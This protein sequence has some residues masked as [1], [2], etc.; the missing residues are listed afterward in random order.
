M[1]TVVIVAQNEE[2]RI[3]ACVESVKFGDQLI[4]VDSGSTDGTIKIASKYVNEVIELPSD[5]G[6]S[7]WR[8][9]AMKKA[10]GDWVLYI[11]ADERVTKEAREEILSTIITTDKSAFA[12]K[13]TNIIFGQEVHYGPWRNDRMF[14]LFKKSEFKEWTGTIHESA[15]FNGEYGYI[16]NPILHLTHRDVDSTLL[17]KTF[18]WSKQDAELRLDAG[19]PKM[20][21]WRFMRIFITEMIN[22]GIKRRG[23]FNGTVGVIDSMLSV[24][25]MFLTY[26]RLWELQQAKP[27]D[28]FYDDLDKKLIENDFKY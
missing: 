9:E 18:I 25:S 1:L 13:R 10:S 11:D 20:T 28:K 5:K 7:Y 21:G 27:L 8:N 19:H 6:F 16:Q 12:I 14:R 22:Q 15:N 17:K 3:K 2:D 24:F 4:L 26:V 23:F